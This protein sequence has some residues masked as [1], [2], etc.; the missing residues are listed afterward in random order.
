[1]KAV[2][3]TNQQSAPII[4]SSGKKNNAAPEYLFKT[5]DNS[6]LLDNACKETFHT[7]TA[8]TLWLS[9]QTRTDVQLAVG[10][11]CTRIQEP[12]EHDWK[13]LTHLM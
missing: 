1:L 8:K 5:T 9:Q 13:K 7:I 3:E 2:K 12:T 10:F 4:M 11:C 6:C